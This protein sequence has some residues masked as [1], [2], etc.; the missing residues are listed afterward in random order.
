MTINES[1]IIL[2][3]NNSA[4]FDDV[5][6]AQRKLIKKYHPDLF[7]TDPEGL[8]RALEATKQI[9]I[10]VENIKNNMNNVFKASVNCK[11]ERKSPSPYSNS[12]FRAS[13]KIQKSYDVERDSNLSERLYGIFNNCLNCVVSQSYKMTGA[14]GVYLLIQKYSCH[15]AALNINFSIIGNLINKMFIF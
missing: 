5:K 9:N 3:L 7:I 10:A 14:F 8:E 6:A 15:S 13:Y 4:S 12:C 1:Y 2:G 11:S